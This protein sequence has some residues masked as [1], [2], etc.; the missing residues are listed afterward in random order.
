MPATW[1]AAADVPQNGKSKKPTAP[2]S[3]A[4]QS[5][6]VMLGVDRDSTD[7]KLIEPGPREL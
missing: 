1:G 3:V 6:P 7:G 2:I 5:M 4:T